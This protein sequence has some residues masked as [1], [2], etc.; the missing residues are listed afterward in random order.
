MTVAVCHNYSFFLPLIQSTFVLNCAL[1]FGLLLPLAKFSPRILL[2]LPGNRLL[3][4]LLHQFVQY[5]PTD[6]NQVENLLSVLTR[7]KILQNKIF[8]VGVD[9]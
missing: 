5:M 1:C 4:G 9:V 2:I 6:T 3:V 7:F 8:K